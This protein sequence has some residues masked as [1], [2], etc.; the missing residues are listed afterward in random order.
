MVAFCKGV[1]GATAMRVA[2]CGGNPAAG[3]AAGRHGAGPL[4]GL[5]PR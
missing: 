1:T 3:G 2:H 4:T 5:N